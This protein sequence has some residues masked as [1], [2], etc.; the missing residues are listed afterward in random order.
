MLATLEL[1]IGLQSSHL[2]RRHVTYIEHWKF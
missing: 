1:V 2:P